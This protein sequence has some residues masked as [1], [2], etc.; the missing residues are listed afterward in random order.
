[1]LSTLLLAALAAPELSSEVDRLA[2]EALKSS[3]VPSFSVAVVKN[4]KLVHAQ[5][6]GMAR[7]ESKTKATPAMHY[8]VGSVSKQFVATAVLMLVDEKKLSLDDKVSRFFPELTRAGDYRVRELLSHTAGLQDYW[9]QDFV[10]PSMEKETTSEGLLARWAKQPLDFEPGTRWQYSNTGYTVAGLI[11]EKVSG[12]KLF[13]FL[14]KRVFGPLEMN[15]LDVD[16]GPLP[17]TDAAGYT[18]YAL[19]P[20]RPAVKEGKGWLFAAGNLAMSAGDLAKWNIAL[21][22]QRLLTPSSYAELESAVRL[23]NGVS[24]QYGLGLD[25]VNESTRRKLRHDGAISGFIAINFVFPDDK[26]AVT[27]LTNDD[28]IGYGVATGLAEKVVPLLFAVPGETAAARAQK[29]FE[30]LQRGQ[31]DRALFSENGSAYFTPTALKDFAS[32]LKGFGKPARVQQTRQSRR[33]GMTTTSFVVTLKARKLGILERDLPDG[34]I[35]QFT[36]APAD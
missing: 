33:G 25:V 17:E 35:E 6:Y 36:V 30:G 31:V 2:E 26:G 15:V 28:G 5:A 23:K 13:D 29:I 1:M 14:Q 20:P 9:P 22:E 16:Q 19:G 7:L 18:R 27:V 24:T 21:M 8:A 12:M 32:S 11:V 3:T 4:G 10:P 34:K